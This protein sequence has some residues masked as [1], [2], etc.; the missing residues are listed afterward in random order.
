M[1]RMDVP[2]FLNYLRAFN[3][4][5]YAKQHAFYSQDVELI[6]P[7]DAIP[8]LKGSKGIMDHY[9]RV[10]AD[11]NEYVIPI[12]ILSDR[13]KVFLEMEAYFEY[14]NEGK[15]VHDIDVVPGDVVK[16]TTCALYHLD[17]DNKM[18]R[19]RCYLGAAE[20]LGKVDLKER[21]RESQSRAAEDIRLYDFWPPQSVL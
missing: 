5:D 2:V 18:Q 4:K 8:P 15:A 11:A 7:D 16:I 3:K 21:V 12:S 19:I 14:F 13:G 17:E 9:G 6:L 10:H 1:P 20:K